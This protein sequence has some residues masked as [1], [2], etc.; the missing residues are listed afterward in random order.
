M[1]ESL[2]KWQ[3]FGNVKGLGM[4]HLPGMKCLS[5]FWFVIFGIKDAISFAIYQS[6]LAY[7]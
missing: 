3:R 5:I 7:D 1:A 4:K 6:Y 2:P